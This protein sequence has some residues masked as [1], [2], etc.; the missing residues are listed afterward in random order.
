M[1]PLNTRRRKLE[2]T[3]SRFDVIID[4][5]PIYSTR[6]FCSKFEGSKVSPDVRVV[7]KQLQHY[8]PTLQVN[9]QLLPDGA[10]NLEMLSGR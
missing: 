8:Q 1:P 3:G 2:R 10:A 4:K 6:L 5:R 9:L 7:P